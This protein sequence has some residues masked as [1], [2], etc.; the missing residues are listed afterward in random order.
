[1]T[2]AGVVGPQTGKQLKW[3]D[4]EVTT[5]GDWLRRH[6]ETT[7]LKPPRGWDAYERDPYVGY[8]RSSRTW[9]PL[10][11]AT[12]HYLYKKYPKK[13]L[14]TIVKRKGKAYCYPHE[15]FDGTLEDRGLKLTRKDKRVEVKD[16][17]GKSVPAMQAYWF[18]WCA[19]YPD[20]VVYD[21]TRKGPS[22]PP[23]GG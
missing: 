9:F 21:P 23:S 18:A 13:S 16:A 20:D 1:M 22:A 12:K 17:Q 19:F 8:H 11:S 4:S 14:V 5:W 7:V 15:A 6:P 2:G 10:G 3:M